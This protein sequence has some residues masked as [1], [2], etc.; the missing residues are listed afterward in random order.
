[1]VMFSHNRRLDQ[2]R[3]VLDDGA[4]IG[5]LRRITSH[6]SFLG[7]EDFLKKN[8][9]ADS[10]LEPLGCL[11]DL[12][13]YCVRFALWTMKYQMPQ[14]VTARIHSDVSQGPDLP[15]V[16]T[17]MRAELLFAGG[18][19]ASFHC[20]FVSENAEWAHVSGTKGSVFVSDFVL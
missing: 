11:G 16:P 2:I 10:S 20:S 13:W 19:S 6:F 3:Q 5:A 14:Q 1:G 15:T 8:I 7:G 18:V 17:E 9:R 12:G 4:S